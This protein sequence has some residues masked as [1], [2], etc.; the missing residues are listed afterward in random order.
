MGQDN[1]FLASFSSFGATLA[2]AAPGVGIVSTV[3]TR[4]GLNRPYM[5]MDGTSMASPATCGA[6]AVMLSKDATYKSLP[7][8]LSRAKRASLVFSQHC[9]PFGLAVK[10]EGR[11]LPVV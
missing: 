9:K 6:L 7:R 10:Y 5:E 3:P 11:G 1:L 2:C 4:A 8:D